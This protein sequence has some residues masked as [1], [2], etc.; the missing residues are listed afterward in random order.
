MNISKM[1]KIISTDEF[2]IFRDPKIETSYYIKL[3]KKNA[4]LLNSLIRTHIILGG[5]IIDNYQTLHFKI[6][7]LETYQQYQD[8]LYIKNGTKK[9]PYEKACSMSYFLGKQLNY[10]ISNEDKCFYEFNTQYIIVLDDTKFIYLSGSHL[11][12]M[13]QKNIQ[14]TRPFILKNENMNIHFVS[15]E[16]AKIK[17]LPSEIHFKT[18]FYSLAFL[19]VFS[20]TNDTEILNEMQNGLINNSQIETLLKPI[21]E[22]KLYWLIKRCLDIEPEKRILMLI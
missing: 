1:T 13:T 9:F 22:T 14:I 7:S 15:P 3:I 21:K 4:S 2:E 19:L 10:L 16:F 8:T 11:L 18:I 17:E 5:S 20:L 6:S 12:E